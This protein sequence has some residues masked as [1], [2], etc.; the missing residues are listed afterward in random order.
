MTAGEQEVVD[1]TSSE[2]SISSGWLIVA[3]VLAA[4]AV[5][6]PIASAFGRSGAV[7]K[8][9]ASGWE[10]VHDLAIDPRTSALLVATHTGL[11]RVREGS[12][13]RAGKAS[14]QDLMSFTVD[15]SGRFLASGHPDIRSAELG[16]QPQLLGLLASQDQ[17]RTWE[18]VSLS[19]AADFHALGVQGRW[20]YGSDSSTGRFM[21]SG[22]GGETWSARSDPGLTDFVVAADSS[23]RVLGISGSG[24][25]LSD[26][27]GRT[28]RT[29]AA[30]P[31]LAAVASDNKRVVGLA[32]DG[33][34]LVS[35]DF[36]STW[37]RR[38]V[39][40]APGEALVA[41]EGD[42]IYAAGTGAGI[43]VSADGGLNWRSL[44]RPTNAG[45]SPQP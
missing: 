9:S 16:I 27:G 4:I 17:A 24:T 33:S 5:G 12:A 13:E 44:Y 30:A 28:W 8:T 43:F 32:T 45:G 19:G 6:W 3:A 40:G 23:G 2:L 29:L 20:V 41:A 7:D 34:I 14:F 38:G 25:L 36:G 26:D 39:I 11:F 42:T 22:D 10:H 31:P 37:E 35:G 1:S 15:N 21:V 18:P